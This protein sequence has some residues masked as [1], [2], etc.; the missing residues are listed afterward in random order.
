MKV[1]LNTTMLFLF[2]V[3]LSNKAF[4]Q[5]NGS[6]IHI[7]S[8]SVNDDIHVE[9]GWS[10]E[11][12]ITEGYFII[13]RRREDG[14]QYDSIASTDNLSARQFI[15]TK[16]NAAECPKSYYISAIEEKEDGSF[17]SFARSNAHQTIFI[18]SLDFNVCLEKININWSN[19]LIT[20]AI[21]TPDT[22][23]LPFDFNILYV[24]FENEKFTI[25][26]TIS[27]SKSNALYPITE[28]GKYC[29][30][31]RSFDSENREITSTSNQKC[32]TAT[33]LE[34]PDFAYFRKA[35]V[36]DNS[37]IRLYLQVDNTVTNPAYVIYGAENQSDD[38][39]P[40][41]TINS[42][43]PQ[44]FYD[45]N[46]TVDRFAYRYY[47]DVLDSCRRP[48]ISSNTVSSILL[49]TQ[50][51]SENE[52]QLQWNHPESFP[53]G[54]DQYLIMRKSLNDDNFS[55]IDILPGNVNHYYDVLTAGNANIISQGIAYKIKAIKPPVNH[56]GFIDTISSNIAEVF[57]EI[58]IFIPTAFKPEST[59]AENQVFKPVIRNAV[60]E[61][62][63]FLVYSNWGQQVFYTNDYSEAW[64]G[65]INGNKAPAGTFLY[66][67]SFTHAGKTYNRK[68]SVILIR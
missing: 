43:Q 29:F 13:H 51:V 17:Q 58:E 10:F 26:D 6:T 55:N 53:N 46:V 21:G 31:I 56:F 45:D 5:N 68:G 27:I 28:T 61:N 19:Y 48:V 66:N 15:D 22:L 8:V 59:I 20:T 4:C 44:L 32:I 37:F 67:I 63:K 16:T 30:K 34:P 11:T 42:N 33:K 64:N 39:L 38:F 9:I 65:N 14:P 40:V 47:F 7:D 52:N 49:Q 35:S 18:E 12:D 1:G 36:I 60:P 57:H 25:A 62:Y 24:L 3:F 2:L 41:D 54:I 23:D 50:S